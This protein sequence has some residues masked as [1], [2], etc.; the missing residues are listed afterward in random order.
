MASIREFKGQLRVIGERTKDVTLYISRVR[1]TTQIR[2][3]AGAINPKSE[4]VHI[5]TTGTDALTLVDGEE[6]DQL[7]LV[8]KTDGGVGTLAP[9]NLANGTNITFDDAGDSALLYYTNNAWH[10]MGGTATLA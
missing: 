3:G 7:I 10:F 2:T 1:P 9:D 8:M 5:V 4:V 6:H